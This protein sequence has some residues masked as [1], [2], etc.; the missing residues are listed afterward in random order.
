MVIVGIVLS[1]V[2]PWYFEFPAGEV[3]FLLAY[4]ASAA[5]LFYFTFAVIGYTVLGRNLA[6][7]PTVK[8]LVFNGPYSIVRHPI[9]SAY[10]MMAA[11]LVIIPIFQRH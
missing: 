6:I 4:I 5:T 7:V 11:T 2:A 1:F 3:N 10:L 9:Y 8:N